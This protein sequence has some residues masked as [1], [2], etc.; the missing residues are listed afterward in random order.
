MKI[1]LYQSKLM[2]LFNGDGAVDNSDL[3]LLF[4]NIENSV[5]SNHP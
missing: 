2:D 3:D 1:L 4:S 5:F